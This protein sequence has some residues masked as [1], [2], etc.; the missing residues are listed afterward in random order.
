MKPAYRGDGDGADSPL[1]GS[2]FPNEL[3]FTDYSIN[4][5]RSLLVFGADRPSFSWHGHV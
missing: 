5:D 2:P 3:L 1:D 4:G